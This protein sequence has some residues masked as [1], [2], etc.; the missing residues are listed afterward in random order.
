M[1]PSCYARALIN[2]VANIIQS[3]LLL[4]LPKKELKYIYKDIEQDPKDITR[5]TRIGQN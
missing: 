1:R 2:W 3:L 5:T 4:F